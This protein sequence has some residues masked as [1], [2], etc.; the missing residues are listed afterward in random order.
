MPH[1]S[2]KTPNIILLV[3][4]DLASWALPSYGNA[5]M[6]TPNIDALAARGVRYANYYTASPVCSP[7]RAS[8]LT[9]QMP[10][11][12]GVVDWIA[13]PPKGERS[14][15]FLEGQET[16]VERLE[17]AGYCAGLF[18]KWHLG[19]ASYPAAGFTRWLALEGSHG[20]YYDADFVS[21]AV[22]D[23]TSGYVTDV[24]A[25]AAI[26]FLESFSD[27]HQP[28]L[29]SINFTAP[30]HPWVGQH[31]D[32]FT[33]LYT[34]CAFESCPQEDAHPWTHPSLAPAVQRAV[35]DPRPSLVGYFAAVS[36]MDDAIGRILTSLDD[37]GLT[38]ETVV[39]FTSDNGF[40]CGQHGIWGKG[41]STWPL[42]VFENSVKVP[43]IVTGP[44]WSA[45][46]VID[47]PCSA[48]DLFPTLLK[49]AGAPMSDSVFPGRP[50]ITDANE[51]RGDVVV[52]DEYGE[53]RMI[54]R[55]NDKFVHRFPDGPHELYDL[56]SDPNERNNLV[57]RP[58]F[59]SIR[60]AL[61]DGLL[62]WFSHYANGPYDARFLSVTGRG[63]AHR[64]PKGEH[65]AN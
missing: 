41:N 17:E 23:D 50:L 19:D 5:E 30:H 49:I 51:P 11:T 31:P 65:D 45:G 16:Y 35:A 33:A 57:G 37:L 34:D 9:G 2:P 3:A 58:E 60:R 55:G 62:S 53:T 8:M 4:D 52:C 46:A 48:Y 27:S 25:D 12:H 21:D 42:N 47:Q 14:D 32:R 29:A 20:P 36:A 56:A 54:R 7:A 24:I 10:S 64:H 39:I 1:K 61:E 22:G 28:F 6:V 15:S 40:Q 59:E 43:C 18:G 13:P 44:G 63:Q 26:A 38:E